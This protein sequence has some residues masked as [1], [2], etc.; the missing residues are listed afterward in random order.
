MP[1]FP[2]LR[3]YVFSIVDR[4]IERY[5]LA[6]PFLDVGCGT[7]A[8]AAHLAGKGWHGVALDSSPAA[9]AKARAMLAPFHSVEMSGGNLHALEG[10]S[11][12]TAFIMDVLE[13]VRDDSGLLR[14]V[15]GLLSADGALVLLVPVNP[16][17][18][19]HDDELYGHFRR[20]GWEELEEKIAEAGLVARAWW[21]VT[22]PV[23]WA[24]RRLYLALLPVRSAIQSRDTLTAAS[25]FYNPW[26]DHPFMKTAG[27][28]LGLPVW[29]EPL[30]R[31]Q[32]LFAGS[33]RGHAAMILA[34]KARA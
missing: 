34:T 6:A 3:H 14:A 5:G 33:R 18:W 1:N 9:A 16:A 25:S 23:M 10:R 27:A 20:Y 21:N 12:N 31:V 28:L 13:H 26:D 15:S 32:D 7:G 17:E 30:I 4:W 11:F 8:L 2:P 22:V 19:R 24:L 29:W